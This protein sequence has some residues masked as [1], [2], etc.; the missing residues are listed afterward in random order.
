VS[1]CEVCL[2]VRVLYEDTCVELDAVSGCNRLEIGEPWEATRRPGM[3]NRRVCDECH[4]HN[5]S[6]SRDK[7]KRLKAHRWSGMMRA[8]TCLQRVSR[9]SDSSQQ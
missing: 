7:G 3:Q 8:H 5:G 9:E 6:R 2:E 1:A 4:K